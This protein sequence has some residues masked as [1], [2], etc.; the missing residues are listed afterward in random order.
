MGCG[1]VI[2]DHFAVDIQN[3]II[4][5]STGAG[6]RQGASAIVGDA[7]ILELAMIGGRIAEHF[8]QPQASNG[9]ST[10]GDCSSCSPGP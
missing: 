1:D 5:S 2:P 10:R 4:E 6:A 3:E 9:R 8:R 7:Q